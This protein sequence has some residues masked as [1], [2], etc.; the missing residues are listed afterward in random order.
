MQVSGRIYKH[1]VGKTFDWILDADPY[2]MG[3]FGRIFPKALNKGP[4]KYTKNKKAIRHNANSAKDIHWF[5]SRFT[6]DMEDKDREFLSSGVEEY[7]KAA[8]ALDRIRKGDYEP[9]ELAIPLRTYQLEAVALAQGVGRLLIGDD[10]GLGKTAS[11]IGITALPEAL[12]ALIVCPTHLCRQWESELQ[13][14][15]PSTK[16]HIIYGVKTSALPEDRTH[17][18]TT[19]SRIAAWA[20]E[21]HRLGIKTLIFDEVH[22]LRRL[23]TKKYDASSRLSEAATRVTGLSGTPIINYG[24]EIWAVMDI[25]RPGALGTRQE[26]LTEWCRYEKY[27]R[28]PEVLGAFLRNNGMMIRRTRVDVG[29]ELDPI[30][31]IVLTVDADLDAL[32]AMEAVAAAL[33]QRSLLGGFEEAGRAAREFDLKLRQ[34]TGIAKAKATAEVVSG[35]LDSEKKVVLFGWHHDCYSVWRKELKAFNPVFYTGAESPAE[36]QKSF[37]KFRDDPNCRVF[38]MSLRSGQG[39]DGLQEVASTCVFGEL[40]WSPSVIRQCIARLLRDRQANTV[41]AIFVVVN[42]GSDPPML[43]ILGVKKDQL[44][45]INDLIGAESTEVPQS[46]ILNLAADFLQKHK[47]GMFA[48]QT[49]KSEAIAK[50]EASIASATYPTMDEKVMQDAL[51]PRLKALALTEGW[52]FTRE[53]VLDEDSTIDFKFGRVGLECKIQG[54][55]SEV[56]RQVRRYLAHLDS[57]I[58]LC[59]WMLNDFEIDG[60]SVHVISTAHLALM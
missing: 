60:K 26:F 8:L 25:I 10:L 49:A 37:E 24:E 33:A 13:R 42:D 50:I 36:K 48:G 52:E 39:L 55:K 12:P 14:F 45:G 4:G 16:A 46:R 11:A 19:Y 43:E 22:D 18:I 1:K 15:M 9:V 32:K 35:L 34:A 44:N 29:R 54:D 59:P 6:I 47:L 40:D 30:N 27:V 56:Y 20:D 2:V 7:D 23:G 41:N 31:Q 17:Y 38:V 28:E 58:L 57:I 51:E 5:L 21:L 3:L 53:A